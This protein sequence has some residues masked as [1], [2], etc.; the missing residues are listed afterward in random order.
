MSESALSAVWPAIWD[1]GHE[2]VVFCQDEESGLRAVI[3]LWSTALGPGLGGT[4]FRPYPTVADAVADVLDL[5]KAMG[6]KLS[7]IHI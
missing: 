7:L 5:S 1:A 3:A 6:Y 4:R 2:Q